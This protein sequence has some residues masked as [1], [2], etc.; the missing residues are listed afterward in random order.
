MFPTAYFPQAKQP[1]ISY[2]K[3]ST[4]SDRIALD[5]PVISFNGVTANAAFWMVLGATAGL[6]LLLT[7]QI[8]IL[9]KIENEYHRFLTGQSDRGKWAKRRAS[10]KQWNDTVRSHCSE[11]KIKITVNKPLKYPTTISD[12]LDNY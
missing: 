7:L 1:L 3:P 5:M 12:W 6:F 8:F 11:R 2:T 9:L 10:V 4:I